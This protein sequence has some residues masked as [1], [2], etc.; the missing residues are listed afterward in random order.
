MIYPGG[1]A[2]VKGGD[3]P[4]PAPLGVNS[5]RLASKERDCG[6]DAWCQDTGLL[7]GNMRGAPVTGRK[8]QARVLPLGQPR[9]GG[10]RLARLRWVRSANS[11]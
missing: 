4:R 3:L 5:S 6:L 7:G 2:M 8:V 1:V 10:W 11:R 9:G